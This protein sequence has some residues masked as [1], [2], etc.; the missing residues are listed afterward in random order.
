[1]SLFLRTWTQSLSS[2]NMASIPSSVLVPSQLISAQPVL[3]ALAAFEPVCAGFLPGDHRQP[4]HAIVPGT[5]PAPGSPSEQWD[6]Q[7]RA[8]ARSALSLMELSV[9]LVHPP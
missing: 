5:L 3:W 6:S 4:V 9:S 7:G 8:S 2:P 1:M